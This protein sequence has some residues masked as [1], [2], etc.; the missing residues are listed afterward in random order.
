MVRGDDDGVSPL[1]EEL[2]DGVKVRVLEPRARQRAERRVVLRE[3]ADDVGLGTC[4]R[5]DVEEVVDDDREIGVVDLLDVVHQLAPLLRA[6]Q[7]VERE[8]PVL[9]VLAHQPL[10]KLLLVLV[11]AALLV[12]VE[13]L[14]G[15]QAV[16]GQRHQPREDGVAG[17]LRGGGEDGAVKVVLR[18]VVPAPQQRRNRPP[19]VVAEVVDQQ[20]RGL[21][22]L[23]D[24]GEDVG[25]HERVRHHGGVVRALVD[26]VVVVAAHELAELLIGLAFL[27]GQHLLDALVGGFR[28]FDLPCGELAVERAPVL[29]RVGHLERGRDAA[30]LRTVVGGGLLG[31]QLLLVHVLLDREQH[32]VGVDGLDEVVGDLRPHGFVH[33]VLLLALGGH[34]HGRRGAH[35]LDLGKGFESRHAGH[36]FVEDDQVVGSFGSHVDRVVSVVAGVHFIALLLE[37]QHVGLQQFDFVV[38]PEYFDHTVIGFRICKINVFI[39]KRKNP[40][41]Y[42]V[43]SGFV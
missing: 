33:D 1:G 7:L 13:P 2:E 31:H 27:V 15:H 6:H 19:L 25:A 9:A 16:D 11:L 42:W 24:D 18:H 30:E 37:E 8:L 40:A 39:I 38:D 12:V 22:V 32:L 36:H 4:V 5:K 23:V 26:P 28:Q 34:D 41:V 17:V 29:E 20:Q 35:L 43:G 10:Q 3:F 14:V 21:G